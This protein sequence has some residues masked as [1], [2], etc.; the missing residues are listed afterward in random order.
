MAD[1]GSGCVPVQPTSS[2]QQCIDTYGIE[3]EGEFVNNSVSTLA[4]FWSCG[5]VSRKPNV[6]THDHDPDELARCRALATDAAAVIGPV[7]PLVRSS[8][9]PR[10]E[11][12]F[13]AAQRTAATPNGVD[14]E[15]IRAALGR[16][17]HPDARVLIEPFTEQTKWWQAIDEDAKRKV[18]TAGGQV[19]F[20]DL[21]RR[22][23]DLMRWFPAN[24]LA[25]GSFVCATSSQTGSET[26][27][28]VFPCFIIG[29]SVKG[30]LIGIATHIVE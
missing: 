23:R 3:G 30:S 12:Y 11:P 6:P 27:G 10:T 24:S 2:M 21:V 16:T 25:A 28:C 29:I 7:W 14:E 1:S 17:L 5:M 4:Q 19:R 15:L 20:D 13:V 9:D 22:W 8:D 26:L 18:K